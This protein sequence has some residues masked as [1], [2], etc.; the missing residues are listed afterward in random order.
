ML[1]N[2]REVVVY[3]SG[4]VRRAAAETGQEVSFPLVAEVV[5][6]M[7][8]VQTGLPFDEVQPGPVR[9]PAEIS[10]ELGRHGL[11][12]LVWQELASTETH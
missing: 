10:D 3:T 7:W 12:V 2:V 6:A 5:R 8:R 9:W 4:L 11:A 1:P